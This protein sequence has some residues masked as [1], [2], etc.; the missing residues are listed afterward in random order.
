MTYFTGC[1]TAEELKKAYR[2]LA[3]DLHPDTGGSKEAFQSMQVEFSAAWERLKN[4]HV[5]KDGERYE[6]ETSETAEEYMKMIEE[7]IRLKD[8]DVEICGTWIW[9]SGNT[10]PYKD[11]FR[12]LGFHWS[13]SKI[14]WYFHSEPYSKHH[15][16]ELSLDEIRSMY[17]SKKYKGAYEEP[18]AL[19]A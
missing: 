9:C 13:R 11:I 10:R 15:S 17:G 6:R 3:K 18:L 2:K 8:V 1:R 5:N 19:K 14:A 4:I 16:R 7:L 12:R